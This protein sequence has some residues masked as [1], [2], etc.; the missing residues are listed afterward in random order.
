M[1]PGFRKASGRDLE[2]LVGFVA[3]YYALDGHTFEEG[4][5][6][7]AL[8]TLIRDESLG[9]LW[10]IGDGRGPWAMPV[11]YAVLT[12]GFSLEYGGR[13]AFVDEVFIQEPYRGRG[14]GRRAMEFAEEEAR[15]LGV[16]ALHLEVTRANARARS[17]Y[18]SLGYQEHDRPLLTKVL[19]GSSQ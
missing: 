9:R 2:I 12:L 14:W 6:R 7:A 11:G 5:V 4:R 10:V 13:D 15:N 18:E 16:R 8:E 1:E 3:E 19:K 17:L